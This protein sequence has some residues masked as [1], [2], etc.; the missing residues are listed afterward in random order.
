M[1][2]KR[3]K[4]YYSP[5]VGP[6]D[7]GSCREDFLS[8]NDD[9]FSILPFCLSSSDAILTRSEDYLVTTGY[10]NQMVIT[11]IDSPDKSACFSKE[12]YLTLEV[13]VHE[14]VC[15]LVTNFDMWFFS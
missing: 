2:R 11:I 4:P 12:I 8:L 10:L 3:S 15:P 7:I 5:Q 9:K 6:T 1:G 14:N 13:S